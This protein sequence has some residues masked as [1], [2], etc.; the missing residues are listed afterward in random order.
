[1]FANTDGSWLW[2]AQLTDESRLAQWEQLYEQAHQNSVQHRP[3]LVGY[4][5]LVAAINGL[6]ND[7]RSVNRLPPLPG[8]KTPLDAVDE[9]RKTV[10]DRRMDTKLG[11]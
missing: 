9:R 7:L 11:Y 5:A 4:D 1:M 8:P 6:R 10:T 2:A 3:S